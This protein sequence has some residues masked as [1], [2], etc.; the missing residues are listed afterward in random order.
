[1]RP[2]KISVCIF[3]IDK[4]IITFIYIKGPKISKTTL[5]N[6]NDEE[7]VLP[8]FN[9]YC[10]GTVSMTVWFCYTDSHA[11]QRNRIKNSEIDSNTDFQLIF[12]KDDKGI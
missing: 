6:N 1:M 2:T 4:Q 7:H 8:Y 10:K 11:D 3:Y 5:I 12:N 9:A